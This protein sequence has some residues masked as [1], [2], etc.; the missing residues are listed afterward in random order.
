MLGFGNNHHSSQRLIFEEGDLTAAQPC[1]AI[2]WQVELFPVLKDLWLE[3]Q[4]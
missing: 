2:Q 1:I 3:L 4:R